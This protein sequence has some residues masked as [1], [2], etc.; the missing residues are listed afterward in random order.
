MHGF[1]RFS[2]NP[3]GKEPNHG[4][5]SLRLCFPEL[6]KEQ[7]REG[8][9]EIPVTV[10]SVY[11]KP[12]NLSTKSATQPQLTI[13][14][15]IDLLRLQP[16]CWPISNVLDAIIDMPTCPQKITS[17]LLLPHSLV[18]RTPLSGGGRPGSSSERYRYVARSASPSKR[19]ASV[20]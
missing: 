20:S 9:K 14:N 3:A 19:L 13:D 15:P 18:L 10:F 16:P 11:S 8:K 12:P 7:G 6:G 5:S 4:G 17:Y 2:V 1:F